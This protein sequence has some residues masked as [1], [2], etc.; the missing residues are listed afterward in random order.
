M[1]LSCFCVVVK[2][3]GWGEIRDLSIPGGL[4]RIKQVGDPAILGLAA[5]AGF[6]VQGESEDE[7]DAPLTAAKQQAAERARKPMAYVLDALYLLL[8]ALASPWLLLQALRGKKI[9]RGLLHK[10]AGTLPPD[11]LERLDPSRPLVLFHGVS[12]GEIQ[13][14]RVIVAAFRKRHPD[15]QCVISTTTNTGYDEARSRFADL[16]V[17][18]YPL[19][20]TWAV[21]R[22]LK[23]LNPALIVLAESEL[24]PN[25]LT[26]A[27]RLDVPV[28]V[29]NGRLSPRSAARLQRFGWFTRRMFAKVDV[30]AAQTQEYADH[31]Q[32]LGVPEGRIRVTGNVKFDGVESKRD[33]PRTKALGELLGVEPGQLI[34]IAGSTQ[35]PEEEIAL[36]VYQRLKLAFPTLRLFLVPRHKERF[37]EVA[38]LIERSGEA[39]VRRSSLHPAPLTPLRCVH[40]SDAHPLVLV[41]SIGEL[42]AL[43]G[44]ADVAFVG[45]SLD[46]QRGGQN[47]LEPAAYG[48]A[49]LFGPHV[50]NFHDIAARLVETGAALQVEGEIDLHMHVQRLLRDADERRRRGAVAVRYI[51][52]QQGATE[53]TLDA[54]DDLLQRNRQTRRAA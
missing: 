35:A 27:R 30:F 32:R 42:G 25:F 7:G 39:F 15:W 21:G 11:A 31:Y 50:W 9:R 14:L 54:I 3:R 53:R 28:M 4:P 8:L 33:N 52:S 41:D 20:F 24:W 18:W 38:R 1:R 44:L 23:Q 51:L 29:V 47:M 48:A 16:P 13:V 26:T 37:D 46:G 40:G 12:L 36:R 17:I 34:W 19:D 2:P 43:W 10:F 22:I 5:V 6:H 49:V 45:G